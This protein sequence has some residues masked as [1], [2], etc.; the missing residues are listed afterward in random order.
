MEMARGIIAAMLVVL[1][2]SSEQRLFRSGRVICQENETTPPGSNGLD[3][4]GMS[5]PETEANAFVG[6]QFDRVSVMTL[7]SH[8]VIVE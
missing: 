8:T 1:L 2:S 6:Y 7:V 5:C 3:S 4:T